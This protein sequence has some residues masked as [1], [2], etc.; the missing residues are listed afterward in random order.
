MS[1]AGLRWC[2]HSNEAVAQADAGWTA[3]FDGKNLDNWNAI[4]NANW[5]LEDGAIVADS[6]NGFL[7]S[8][9]AYTDFQLRAEF[10]VDS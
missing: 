9:N 5:K 3:L 6:G 4:G 10:W 2:A 8:K 7:V 1:S